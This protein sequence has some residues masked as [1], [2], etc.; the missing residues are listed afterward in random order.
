M[1]LSIYPPNYLR[2]QLFLVYGRLMQNRELNYGIRLYWYLHF[3]HLRKDAMNDTVCSTV[4][5]REN[6]W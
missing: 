4:Y 3:L 2:N 1:D 6:D 5:I